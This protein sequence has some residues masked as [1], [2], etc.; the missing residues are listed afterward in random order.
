ML[1]SGQVPDD[2]EAMT[3]V[4]I[5][6]AKAR[7]SALIQAVERGEEIVITNRNRPVAR[8][9]R[10]LPARERPMFGVAREAFE[11]SGLSREDMAKALAPMS[12]DELP[13]WGIEYA[14]GSP[15]PVP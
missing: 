3:T 13:E 1:E 8:L 5:Y 12:E 14:A 4:S 10:A 11:R 15:T 2:I 6:E 7:L 9:V